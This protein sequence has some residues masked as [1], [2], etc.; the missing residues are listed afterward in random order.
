MNNGKSRIILYLVG[1]L[2][3]LVLFIT[4]PTMAGY[5]VENDKESRK[6]DEKIREDVTEKIDEVLVE[7]TEMK[8]Q[9]SRIETHLEYL[10]N[11]Q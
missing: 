9:L 4:I 11:N 5:I 7:Q 3:T 10:V 8:C 6:R 1:V 2:V